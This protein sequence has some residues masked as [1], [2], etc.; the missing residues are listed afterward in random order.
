MVVSPNII[1]I[2]GNEESLENKIYINQLISLG[3]YKIET[4]SD[5]NKA[6]KKIKTIEFEETIIIVS[7]SLYNQFIEEFKLNLNGIYVPASM[8]LS[9]VSDAVS[10]AS[11][12]VANGIAA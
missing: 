10:A 9:Y 12:Y 2:D 7:G 5:I 4:F 6:I 1:W 3:Y 11:N 8:L